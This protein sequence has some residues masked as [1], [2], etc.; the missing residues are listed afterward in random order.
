[1]PCHLWSHSSPCRP[2]CPTGHTRPLLGRQ[3]LPVGLLAF[4]LRLRQHQAFGC[5]AEGSLGCPISK[6]EALALGIKAG[7]PVEGGWVQ[8]IY[9]LPDA[10]CPEPGVVLASPVC[11]HVNAMRFYIPF[12]FK[13]QSLW[14]WAPFRGLHS[15]QANGDIKP[16]SPHSTSKCTK[17]TMFRPLLEVEM[18]K[19]CTQLWREAQFQVKMRKAH[20]HRTTVGS[21]RVEKVHAVVARSTLR[22]QNVKHTTCSHHFWTIRF[23]FT[24]QAQGIVHLVKSEKNV[25]VL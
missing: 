5:R 23:R 2:R 7:W 16:R 15:S 24:W 14:P 18:S 11:E 3:T 10:S 19:K 17:H 21:W 22:G 9:P 25:R 13:L 1:M 6:S 4:L 20:Q 8:V 12:Q